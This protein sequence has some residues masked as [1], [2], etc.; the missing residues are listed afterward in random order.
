MGKFSTRLIRQGA[1]MSETRDVLST[2]DFGRSVKDNLYQVVA[3]RTAREKQSLDV[4]D[5]RDV[6]EPVFRDAAP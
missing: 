6:V 3:S 4:G 5:G 1:L 2:W